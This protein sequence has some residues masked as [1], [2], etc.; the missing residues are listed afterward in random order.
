MR[1]WYRAGAPALLIASLAQAQPQAVE[2]FA[3]AGVLRATGDEGSNGTG[4]SVGGAI[5]FPILSRVAI[6][7]D[8]WTA[9]TTRGSSG[10]EFGT[11]QTTVAASLLYRHGNERAYGFV[12][13]GLG[14]QFDREFF[15]PGP[16]LPETT[17]THSGAAVA[18]RGGVVAAVTERV[19][20][21]AELIASVRYLLPNVGARVGLGYRF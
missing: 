11:R 10:F 4:V 3:H 9:R 21:R 17:T 1:A 8:F 16:G 7:V 2:A 20:I 18:L 6:D 5:L 13:G 12:G 15:R 19:L 14:G